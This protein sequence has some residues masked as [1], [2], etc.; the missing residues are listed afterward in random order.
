MTNKQIAKALRNAVG[1]SKTQINPMEYTV[2]ASVLYDR[3]MGIISILE[4]EDE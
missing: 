1:A 3:I 4:I 2:D